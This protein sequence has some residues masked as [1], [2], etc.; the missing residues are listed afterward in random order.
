MKQKTFDFQNFVRGLKRDSTNPEDMLNSLYTMTNYKLNHED[1]M[2]RLEARSGFDRW[3]TE[4][5]PA[6][7]K[8]LYMFTDQQRNDYLIGVCNSK[9]YRFIQTTTH[10][11]IKNEVSGVP[12]DGIGGPLRN[13]PVITVGNR[14]MFATD[15]GW[16]WADSDSFTEAIKSF[17]VGI[18]PPSDPPSV[19]MSAP[20]GSFGAPT[21]SITMNRTTARRIAIPVIPTITTTL[22]NITVKVRRAGSELQVKSGAWK[23]G[24]Y[25]DVAGSPGG[26]IS[27]DTVSQWMS[28]SHFNAGAY[29]YK[30]FSFLKSFT[31]TSGTKYWIIIDGD[32]DYYTNYGIN[33]YGF[34]GVLASL[35]P[36][37]GATKVWNTDL[38]PDAWYIDYV[39][40]GVPPWYSVPVFHLGGAIPGAEQIVDYVVTFYNSTYGIESRKSGSIRVA[41]DSTHSIGQIGCIYAPDAQVDKFRVYRRE[42][43]TGLSWEAEED[44]ITNKYYYMGE[45]TIAVDYIDSTDLEFTGNEIQ[46]D[47]NYRIGETDDLDPHIRSS[48]VV[49]KVATFWKGRTWVGNG[50]KIYFSKKLES[51]GASGLAG[52]PI[53]DYFPPENQIDTYMTNAIIAMKPLADDQLVIYFA[54]S[55]IW[56]MMGMDSVL[57]PPDPSEYRFIEVVTDSG[58]I[59]SSALC[60]LKSRHVYLARKGLNVFNGT[61]NTEFVSE[62]I[63][64]ILNTLTDPMIDNSVMIGMGDELWLGVDTDNDGKL[65]DFY[66][67]DMQKSVPYWRKYNYGVS[68][69]DMVVKESGRYDA[70]NDTGYKTIYASDADNLY[71]LKLETG[72]DDNGQAIECEFETHA[73]RPGRWGFV[74][75][76]ELIGYYPETAPTFIGKATDHVGD[77]IEFGLSPFGSNDVRG[78]RA[79]L[80]FNSP[81]TLKVSVKH[82]AL[83]LDKILGFKLNYNTE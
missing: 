36:S 1:G 56:I 26:L 40:T 75:G 42:L 4:P 48:A 83:A 53:P 57:N 37:Y 66:I 54:N 47:D 59:A 46:T 29:S 74:H 45:S 50:S 23:L 69:Y 6:V 73:L 24:V 72:N 18:D 82:Y 27:I 65:E 25:N 81:Y 51:D 67:F 35:T 62:N 41:W 60:N 78:H 5:L 32:D 64:S 3:N 61:A 22:Q 17:Q 49:P 11:V 20:D 38:T 55:A 33:F 7:A 44:E 15:L 28:V 19:A 34:I 52:D 31:L 70:S 30:T 77:Y 12:Q 71:I 43:D 76:I 9:W 63:Q 39:P 80:R 68:I 14:V 2:A 16:Y 79:G 21:A 58:L 10:E 8:Q 13:L